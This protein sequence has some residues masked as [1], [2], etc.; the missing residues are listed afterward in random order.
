MFIGN[1]NVSEV[2]VIFFVL[3]L[4]NTIIV[5]DEGGYIV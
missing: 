2:I 1:H 3:F 4:H 5:H